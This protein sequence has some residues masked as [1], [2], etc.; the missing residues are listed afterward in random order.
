MIGSEGSR[1]GGFAEATLG[2]NDLAAE[3]SGLM[4]S[5][6]NVASRATAM[7]SACR[8]LPTDFTIPLHCR[9]TASQGLLP[10]LLYHL[11][12]PAV[13]IRRQFLVS[14]TLVRCV[15]FGHL[16]EGSRLRAESQSR[17]ESSH[18]KSSS[19]SPSP[20]KCIRLVCDSVWNHD[21][22][23]AE[24]ILGGVDVLPQQLVQGG[25]ACQRRFG[26]RQK[27]LE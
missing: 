13:R 7:A 4:S 23:P 14:M 12:R 15:P 6:S 1:I 21:L 19:A 8:T 18:N 17:Y 2:T 3:N 27:G 10:L 5:C 9:G 11:T 22:R 25:E 24:L 16:Y 26:R 20:P